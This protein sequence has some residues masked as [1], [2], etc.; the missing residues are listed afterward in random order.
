MQTYFNIAE[1]DPVFYKKNQASKGW[2][3]SE[4]LSTFSAIA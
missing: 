3:A 2:E 1:V 4:Y